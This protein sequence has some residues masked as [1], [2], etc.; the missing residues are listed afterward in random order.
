VVASAAVAI[1]VIAVLGLALGPKDPG[2]ITLYGLVIAL[3][4]LIALAYWPAVRFLQRMKR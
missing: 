2:T 1:L 4:L 3:N